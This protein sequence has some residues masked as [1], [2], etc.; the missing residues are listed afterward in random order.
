M[1]KIENAAC[2][3]CGKPL[4]EDFGG[5]VATRD[6]FN[7]AYG[8][9]EAFEQ[10]HDALLRSTDPEQAAAMEQRNALF[11]KASNARVE[12]GIA[13]RKHGLLDQRF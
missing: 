10:R 6:A 5:V 4:A 13:L 9:F 1:E 12:F 3:C 2:T 7:K 8:E 11:N